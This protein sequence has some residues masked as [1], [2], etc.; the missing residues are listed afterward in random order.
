MRSVGHH[1]AQEPQCVSHRLETRLSRGNNPV[2]ERQEWRID[3]GRWSHSVALPLGRNSKGSRGPAAQGGEE[4][5]EEAGPKKAG[6]GTANTAG[7][8]VKF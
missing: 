5:E 6:L 2:A 3:G 4:A 7:E 1:L 8:G